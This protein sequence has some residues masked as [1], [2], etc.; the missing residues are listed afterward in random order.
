MPIVPYEITKESY[1]LKSTFFYEKLVSLGFFTMF[2][3]VKVLAKENSKSFSWEDKSEWGITNDAWEIIQDAGVDPLLVFA[4][5][6]ILRIR[7]DILKYYR[8]VAMLPQ[9]GFQAISKFSSVSQVETN[10]RPI[11]ELKLKD[12][13]TTINEVMSV[14]IKLAT[15]INE[16]QLQGMMYATAGTNIDGSWRNSIGA[17]GERVIRS[18][19]LKGLLDNAEVVSFTH[20]NNKI[21]KLIDWNDKDPVAEIS[22]IKSIEILNGSIILFSSEPDV[23]LMSPQG[24]ILGGIEIK[25]G[26]DPAGALER[27]GAMFKS[28]E[29]IKQ[30]YPKAETILVASCITTEVES[31]IRES[32]SVTLTYILTDIINNKRNTSE[33]FVNNV[34]SILGLIQTRM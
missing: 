25:A 18:I 14:V 17:E 3:D 19:I 21:T 6:N 26:L 28:F 31:R 30:T 24:K 29:E 34:R 32:R 4:H 13:I 12:V 33:K 27:L 16:N 1:V 5:P 15:N 22:T 8:C 7:P 23:T 9:K 20:K 11:P 2:A 10:N